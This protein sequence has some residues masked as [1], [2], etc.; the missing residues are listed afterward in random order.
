M[1]ILLHH[2][3]LNNPTAAQT[4]ITAGPS[5]KGETGVQPVVNKEKHEDYLRKHPFDDINEEDIQQVMLTEK[6]YIKTEISRILTYSRTFHVC[7]KKKWPHRVSLFSNTVFLFPL[8][9]FIIHLY[10]Q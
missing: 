10:L 7:G 9:S 1:L 2:D 5:K 4:G 8:P 6:I 3:A